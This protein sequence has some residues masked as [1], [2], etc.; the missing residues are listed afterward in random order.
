MQHWE[1]AHYTLQV[2]DKK[3]YEA[4][5]LQLVEEAISPWSQFSKK[6]LNDKDNGLPKQSFRLFC[7]IPVLAKLPQWPQ[8]N[9]HPISQD[10]EKNNMKMLGYSLLMGASNHGLSYHVDC[11]MTKI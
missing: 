7:T 6:M 2:Y 9:A 8:Q 3:T 1:N 4:I 10:D 5:I 11:F